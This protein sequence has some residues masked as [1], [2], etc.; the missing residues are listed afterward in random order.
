MKRLR[1][2]E[3]LCLCCIALGVL[4]G[5]WRGFARSQVER[6]NRQVEILLDWSEVERTATLS[7]HP[8]DEV[9]REF[10][11][12]GATSVALAEDTLGELE[13]ERQVTVY[14][15]SK[16]GKTSRSTKI[17]G[18]PEV[19][20]RVT[21]WLQNRLPGAQGSALM[22]IEPRALRINL[23][24]SQVRSHHTKDTKRRSAGRWTCGKRARYG[25]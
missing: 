25:A 10:R 18:N 8:I 24:Y 13:G 4:V 17:V 2:V 19:L 14:N 21:L 11:A 3:I 9:L 22:T 6:A 16:T 23:P 7:G 1:P 20:R 5:L 15:G 12:A